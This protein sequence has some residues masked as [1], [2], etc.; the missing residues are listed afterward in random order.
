VAGAN[1]P[2]TTV[3]WSIVETGKAAGTNVVDGV[4]TVS[5][6]ETLS[7][8]TVKAASTVDSSKYGTATI[9]VILPMASVQGK[10]ITGSGSAG[11]FIEGRAVTLSPFRIAKHLTTWKLWDSVYQWATNHGYTFANRGVEGFPSA[12]DGWGTGAI[13]ES[14]RI[15]RPVGTISWR[16]MV[17]WCNAYSEKEGLDPVYTSDGTTV[18]KDS[19]D[20]AVDSAVANLSKNGYRLPTEAEWEFAFRGGDPDDAVNWSYTYAGS[21]SI[22]DVAWYAGNATVDGDQ[23]HFGIN[24]VGLL[25][26]NALGLYDMSGNVWEFCW[27]WLG[28][29]DAG[30]VTDPLGP[31]GPAASKVSR[32]SAWNMGNDGP[33]ASWS[34][35]GGATTAEAN[36]ERGFRV[37]QSITE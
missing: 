23:P 5:S 8:L 12:G 14:Q 15:L 7:S 6:Q 31:I 37:V 17:V 20:T 9:T 33:Y 13:V 26:P 32:G 1:N 36:R 3:N 35:R 16:D 28:D 27:D 4:L 34:F 11:V 18:L 2:A 29:I 19:G 10:T 22:G 25:A 21:N 24:P 30:E